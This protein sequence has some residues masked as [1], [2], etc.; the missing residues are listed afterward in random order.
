MNKP[1]IIVTG[2]T[3]K[4]GSVVVTELLKAGYPVRAMVHREDDRSARLRPQGAEIVIADMSDVERIADASARL[5][6]SALRS[7]HY[8]GRGRL[9]SCR[10]G[11][12]AR[13]DRWPEPMAG[14]SLA[15][16][17]RNS[18]ELARGPAVLND[19]GSG[20]YDHQ[21]GLFR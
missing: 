14:E 12:A 7:L 17:T 16:L 5:L 1:R 3:G 19:A 9:R 20:A 11:I 4:T 6:L 8:S 18:P 21:P 15:S 13:T 2:A 10:E